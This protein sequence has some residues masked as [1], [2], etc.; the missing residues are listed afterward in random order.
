MSRVA[1]IKTEGERSGPVADKLWLETI[2]NLLRS[3]NAVAGMFIIGALALM[4]IFAPYIATHDP[5][6]SMIGQ[7]GESGRLPA[8][9]PCIPIFADQAYEAETEEGTGLFIDIFG[10]RVALENL[11]P[12]GCTTPLHW[13]GLDLNARDVFSRIV[14]GSRTSLVVGLTAV[15]LAITGGTILGLVAGYGGAVEDTGQ[16]A[17]VFGR[18]LPLKRWRLWLCF[19]YP[20]AAVADRGG[21]FAQRILLAMLNFGWVFGVALVLAGAGYVNQNGGEL[22]GEFWSIATNL[23]IVALLLGY[24]LA[25]VT[26]LLFNWPD[27]IIMRVMDVMLAFPS[28]ILAIAIVTIRGPGLGNALIGIAIVQI[29]AYARLTRASVLQVKEMEFITAEKALGANPFR[30]VLRHIFPN[31]LTPIIV[32]GTLGIGTAVLDAAALSFLGLGA[33]PPTAEWGQMLSEARS[34]VFTAPHMVFFPGI[35][36]MITVLGFNLLGDGMRDALDPRLNRI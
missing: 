29:P 31:T 2:K 26:A 13:M 21:R 15:A 20:P 36:I 35:A 3:R 12:F 18:D 11:G 28:L 4:A 22:N 27:D 5:N 9:P 32:Q 23:F 7:P 16:S 33:Q 30:I 6:L 24:A 25:V 34:Y 17:R 8:R 14:W 1:E 19:L 10:S